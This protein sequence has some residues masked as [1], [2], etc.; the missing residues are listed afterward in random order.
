MGVFLG[1]DWSARNVGVTLGETQDARKVGVFV[2]RDNSC[3]EDGIS[4]DETN[5][6]CVNDYWIIIV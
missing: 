4:S 2:G 5:C 6:N 3:A 1:R